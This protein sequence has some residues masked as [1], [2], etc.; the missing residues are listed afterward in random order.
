MGKT[1]AKKL[2]E[3]FRTI[4][5]LES[6]SFDELKAVDEVGERIA[7]SIQRFFADE[8]AIKLV[9][10]LKNAGLSMSLPQKNSEGLSEKL[11]G[12]TFVISGTFADISREDLKE[13]IEQ[14]GGKNLAAVSGNLNYLVAGEKIGPAK[15]K[16]ASELGVNII[17]I[18]E[19]YNM[20]K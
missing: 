4:E 1:T 2:A 10:R 6:A 17:S 8:R 11:K 7:G 9:T 13:L 16:K 18:E 3:H 20:L 5:A 19:L 15:L 12:Y 14:H